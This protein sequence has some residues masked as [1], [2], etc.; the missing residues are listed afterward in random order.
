MFWETAAWAM[1]QPAGQEGPPQLNFFY[2]LIP[3]MIIFWIFLILPQKR[4]QQKHQQ[5]ISSLKKGDR[6]ITSGGIYGT[7]VKAEEQSLI[8]S[9]AEVGANPSSK[10][11][12]GGSESS[13]NIRVAKS[14]IG[15]ILE[16][17]EAES[18]EDSKDEE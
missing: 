5:Q 4:Q 1:A 2:I 13:V 10:K 7:V 9:I 8:L 14:A 15:T 18:S 11:K 6:V 12:G 3:L 17:A 16:K